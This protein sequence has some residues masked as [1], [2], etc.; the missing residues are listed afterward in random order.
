MR[1]QDFLS[2]K[3]KDLKFR[4]SLHDELVTTQEEVDS[5]AIEFSEWKDK[6]CFNQEDGF[7]NRNYKDEAFTLKELLEIFKKEKVL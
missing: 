5:F 6:N 7:Y 2:G 1:P 3:L 4:I